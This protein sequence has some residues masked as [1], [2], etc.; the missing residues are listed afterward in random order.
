MNIFALLLGFLAGGLSIVLF[1]I[2]AIQSFFNG[3]SDFIRHPF[4][5]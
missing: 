3:L 1:E 2:Q 5:M 4:G